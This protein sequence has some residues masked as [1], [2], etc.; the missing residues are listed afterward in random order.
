MSRLIAT[1]WHHY[2]WIC[3]QNNE[4]HSHKAQTHFS[5]SIHFIISSLGGDK[6]HWEPIKPQAFMSQ[7]GI[8]ISPQS[9][10]YCSCFIIVDQPEDPAPHLQ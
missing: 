3:Y 10:S 7:K 5:Q 2:P 6:I 9:A 8:L 1:M 4:K